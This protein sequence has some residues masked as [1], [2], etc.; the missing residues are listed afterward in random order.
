MQLNQQ[1]TGM[2]TQTQQLLEFVKKRVVSRD[3]AISYA[4]RP[5]ELLRVLDQNGL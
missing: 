5:E 1:E 4:N 2:V 3:T